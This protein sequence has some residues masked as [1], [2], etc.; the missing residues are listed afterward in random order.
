MMK[1][2]LFQ[3]PDSEKRSLLENSLISPFRSEHR[4]NVDK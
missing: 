1:V 4:V 2:L 3:R